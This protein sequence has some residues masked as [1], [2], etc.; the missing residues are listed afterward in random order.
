MPSMTQ[1]MDAFVAPST[2]GVGDPTI[3][4]WPMWGYGFTPAHAGVILRGNGFLLVRLTFTRT[5]GDVMKQ[6]ANTRY[7]AGYVCS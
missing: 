4:L 6:T 1:M 3:V 2:G 5:R 7:G